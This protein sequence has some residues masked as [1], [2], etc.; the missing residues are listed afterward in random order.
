MSSG[1]IPDIW[2]QYRTVLPGR[3]RMYS[4]NLCLLYQS[5]E[6]AK[7]DAKLWHSRSEQA[8][9]MDEPFD[10]GIDDIIPLEQSTSPLG[11]F[12]E[13]QLFQESLAQAFQYT[14][15]VVLHPLL[16]KFM[17]DRHPTGYD[18]ASQGSRVSFDLFRRLDSY[19]QGM[20]DELRPEDGIP[21]LISGWRRTLERRNK[22]MKNAILGIGQEY[23]SM[24]DRV[25]TP[26][27]TGS[28]IQELPAGEQ[29]DLDAFDIYEDGGMVYSTPPPNQQ[30]KTTV[31]REQADIR[32]YLEVARDLAG[33]RML[34][35]K[36][37][38]FLLSCARYLDSIQDEGVLPGCPESGS[39]HSRP[40]V[41]PAKEQKQ[42]FFYLGG[43]G[44]TGKSAC[45]S[46]LVELFKRKQKRS[47]IVVTAMSGT[48]AF[49]IGG[50]TIHS[51]LRLRTRD[52][53]I[54]SSQVKTEEVL[55]WQAKEVLLIDECSMLSAQMLVQIDKAL[56]RFRRCNDLP[57][58]GIPIVLLTGDFMQ[59]PPIGGSSLVE[60]PTEKRK[61]QQHDSKLH[62]A[63]GRAKRDHYTGHELFRLFDKV[64]I[65]TEQ[66][67]Q[68]ADPEFGGI[69]RRLRQ[70]K[71]TPGDLERVNSRVIPLQNIDIFDGRQFITRTNAVRHAVNLNA[72]SQFAISK[73]Q[74]LYIFLSKHWIS[75]GT[76]RRGAD[77][78]TNSVRPPTEQELLEALEV[79]DNTNNHI[80]AYF[81][82]IPG[83]PIMVTK[84]VFQSLG[85]ANGSTFTVVDILPDL[86]SERIELPGPVIIYSKPPIC[87][88][89]RSESTK[90]IQ[91]PGLDTG[92]V[93]L[94]PISEPVMRQGRSSSTWRTGLPCTPGFA[95]TDYKSQSQTFDEIYLDI[96]TSSSFSSLYVQLSRGRTLRGVSLLRPIPPSVW[97]KEPSSSTLAGMA[98]LEELSKRTF[99]EWKDLLV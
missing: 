64:I 58:G 45:N 94:L 57:F 8:D 30:R 96:D 2:Q 68:C 50:I 79:M 9:V 5:A 75:M 28:I 26:E 40:A 12:K 32:S 95:I 19:L 54:Q 15:H 46:S 3:I 38:L 93:S 73:G 59:F 97:N 69:L 63:L 90:S 7:L 78:N 84:N 37:R 60:N 48:A 16:K 49:N 44:G 83:V 56:K 34:N 51:A 71:Q 24:Q 81:P 36:Q 85:V 33:E 52:D 20:S 39:D 21:G 53:N 27:A 41:G 70:H 42:L 55:C 13:I 31:T 67:R 35:K 23:T 25:T 72:A 47:A 10:D 88:L 65:L 43:E 89:I 82:F 87:L 14:G 98:R 29:H 1:K 62:E 80:P 99:E 61:G 11:F 91:L 76:C 4:D 66:M 22:A 18:D 74:P 92:V 77:N 6:D 86:S 17:Y